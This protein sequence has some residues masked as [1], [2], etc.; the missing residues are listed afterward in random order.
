MHWA[1]INTSTTQI[2]YSLIPLKTSQQYSPQ[3]KCGTAVGAGRCGG[4][5]VGLGMQWGRLKLHSNTTKIKP[6]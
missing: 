6:T 3:P 5:R 1:R 2:H 4:T